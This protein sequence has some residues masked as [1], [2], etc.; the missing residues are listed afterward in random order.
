MHFQQLPRTST[1]LKL[2]FT[3]YYEADSNQLSSGSFALLPPQLRSLQ[4]LSPGQLPHLTGLPECLETLI[5]ADAEYTLET[6]NQ[7]PPS[8]KT[9]GLFYE[10]H[11]QDITLLR[12]LHEM[13]P[14]VMVEFGPFRDDF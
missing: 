11:P 13:L 3:G 12:S 6:F 8:L 5:F 2:G 9:L 4:L 10:R 7:F 14:A 1:S